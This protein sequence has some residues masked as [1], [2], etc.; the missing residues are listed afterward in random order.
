MRILSVLGLL[1][2]SASLD[3]QPAL[4]TAH[5]VLVTLDGLRWQEVFTGADPALIGHEDF[6][7]DPE[8]LREKFWSE[9]PMLRREKLLPFFWSVLATEGQLYGNRQYGS[10]VNVT[11]GHWFSYPGYNEILTGRADDR[12]D[13]NDKL[14]NSNVTVLEFFNRMPQ[15]RNAVAAFAS[16]DVF[17]YIINEKRSG[18]PVNGGFRPAEGDEL[19][20]RERFLNVLQ[21]QTPSPWSTV[22]LD[23][24]THHYALEYMKKHQPRIV[25]IAYGETDDFAHD[26][27]YDAY[28][29]A[30]HRTDAFIRDLWSFIQSRAPYRNT[31]TLIVTTD[32]GRGTEPLDTWKSHGTDIPGADQIWLSFIGPDTSALGEIRTTGQ[33]YQN[34][35]AS[36]LAAFLGERY[37][38]DEDVGMVIDEAIDSSETAQKP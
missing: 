9:D 3:A 28:L 25:Y 10:K 12:I 34:Q 20:E 32:H 2:L 27:E 38:S 31:T 14:E 6:V 7:S 4:D 18:I 5:I 15:Y 29:Q 11:N 21:T 26:G 13:S 23:A 30:A 24:F 37:T 36:T 17:P 33:L 1:A 19:S 35:V 22:R 8:D 16:W